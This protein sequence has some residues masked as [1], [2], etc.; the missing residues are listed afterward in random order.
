MGAEF[1]SSE[2][3]ASTDAGMPLDDAEIRMASPN[4]RSGRAFIWLWVFENDC[5]GCFYFPFGAVT[6]TA[7]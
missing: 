5:H 4:F 1:V 6:L 3:A 7:N 2:P